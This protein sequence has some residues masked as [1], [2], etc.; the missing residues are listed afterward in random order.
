MGRRRGADSGRGVHGSDGDRG[1]GVDGGAGTSAV[2]YGPATASPLRSEA[3][4]QGRTVTHCPADMPH[5]FR[6]SGSSCLYSASLSWPL[7]PAISATILISSSLQSSLKCATQTTARSTMSY[8]FENQL[9]K[10]KQTSETQDDISLSLPTP[11]SSSL[12]APQKTCKIILEE[13]P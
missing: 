3:H 7:H 13:P 10:I 2:L 5:A 8:I 9:F 4:C 12:Q 1:A 6:H 11:K